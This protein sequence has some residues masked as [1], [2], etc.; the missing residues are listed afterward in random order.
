MATA[1]ASTPE[2]ANYC[3]NCGAPFSEAGPKQDDPD[4][5]HL[6]CEGC[7]AKYHIRKV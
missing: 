2:C 1:I 4:W 6:V 5:P 3:P 7:G